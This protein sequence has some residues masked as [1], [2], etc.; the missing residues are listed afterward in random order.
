MSRIIPVITV[1]ATILGGGAASYSS[2]D[3]AHAADMRQPP[4]AASN[5]GAAPDH[6]AKKDA[7]GHAHE[8]EGHAEGVKLTADQL[9]EFGIVVGTA[10]PGP[11]DVFID[12][13]NATR[14]W[15]NASVKTPPLSLSPI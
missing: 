1:L 12:L 11:L 3:V 7:D 6:D 10:E 9:K 2:A 8:E 5:S 4:A 14:R 15:A 13:P